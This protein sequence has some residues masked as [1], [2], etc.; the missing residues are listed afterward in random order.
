MMFGLASM[1][2]AYGINELMPEGKFKDIL[3]DSVLATE[4]LN[5]E[6]NR[7]AKNIGKRTFNGIMLIMSFDFR[8]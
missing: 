4:R 1:T 2:I 3:F 5:I 7:R 6:E 8:R